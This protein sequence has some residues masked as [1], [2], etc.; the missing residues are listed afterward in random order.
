MATVART[1]RT[2]L[3][4]LASP[5]AGPFLVGFRLFDTDYLDIYVNGVLRSDRVVTTNFLNGY[6]DNATFTFNTTLLSGDVIQIDGALAPRRDDDYLPGDP[7]LIRKLNIELARIWSA[8][9]EVNMKVGRSVRSNVDVGPSFG[10]D[11]SDITDAA[12]NATAAAASAVIAQ[13]YGGLPFETR[14]AAIAATI[15]ETIKAISVLHD[16]VL[17]DYAYDAAGT[18][19]TTA[20]GRNWSPSGPVATPKHY[21]AVADGVTDD[22]AVLQLW[23][24]SAYLELEWTAGTYR[25]NGA[26][27][28]PSN[29]RIYGVR[30][31]TIL[32]QFG[33]YLFVGPDNLT[34]LHMSG[35]TMDYRRV[36]GNIY[37]TA[38]S[39]RAHQYCVFEDFETLRYDDVTIVERTP[40]AAA[41]QNTIDNVYRDW[42]ISACAVLDVAIGLE[43]YYYKHTGDG[44]ATVISTNVVWPEL[45]NSS[46]VV[47]KETASRVFTELTLTTDYTVSYDGANKLIVTM[48]VAPTA[49]ERIHIWPSAPRTAGNRRPISNNLFENIRC[50]Y[51]FKRG[52]QAVRW[53]DAETYRFERLLAAADSVFLYVTNPYTTRD[54]QGG[55]YAAYEDSIIGYQAALVATPT[56][57]RGFDFGPGSMSMSGRGIRAD[58]TWYLSGSNRVMAYR[59]GRVFALTGTVSGTSGTPDVT[60][61][62]TKFRDQ[63]TLVGA[64]ADMVQIGG[65]YYAI[66]SINSDTS[67]TLSTNLSTSPAGAVMSRINKTAAVGF[68]MDFASLGNGFYS[69]GSNQLGRVKRGS[70]TET[71][72]TAVIL[73]TTSSVVVTHGL[74]RAPLVHEITLVAGSLLNGRSMSVS[75]RTATTFQINISSAAVANYDIGWR[76]NLV[77]LN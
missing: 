77:E 73:D 64:N 15:P 57:L 74:M 11:P 69:T 42:N 66:A 3:I 23:L 5:S 72:G 45:F 62:G 49:L 4:T 43:G 7:G 10:L 33:A 52:H 28:L 56:T 61:V 18:A 76:C 34:N 40:N 41:T 13:L 30:G 60:G 26:L 75:N 9:S 70:V 14:A 53:V 6:D 16:G 68:N 12:A 59:D 39:L 65:V 32:Q 27:T 50:L 8:V 44:V 48:A 21:G 31:A 51:V 38:L 22:T 54:G 46:V 2:N 63:L 58:Q 36:G 35:L 71:S 1:P 37:D 55:D 20:G 25:I 29:K 19:L 67:L 17:C 47:L 24:S